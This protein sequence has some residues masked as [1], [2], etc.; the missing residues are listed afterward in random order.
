MAAQ[1]SRSIKLCGT[2][3]MDAPSRVLSAGALSVELENGQLRYIRIGGVEVI[4]AIAFLVR[5]ENWGTFTPTLENLKVDERAGGF[6]VTYRATCKDQKRTLVYDA[7]ITGASDGSLAFEVIADPVTDVETNRTGFIVLHPVKGIAG[8]PVK[9]LQVDG[10][11]V[12]SKFPETIDPDCP[13]RDIRALSHEVTPGVWATCTMEGDTF[14]MEDQRNWSDAS[15]KTY[16]RPLARP[17]PYTLPKGVKVEQAVRLSISGQAVAPAAGAAQKP[18]EIRLGGESGKMPAI[19]IGVP[20]EEAE[21]AL[22]SID[23]VKTLGPKWLACQVDLRQGHGRK[24]L[25]LYRQARRGD[26]RRNRARNRHQ[27]RHESR[28]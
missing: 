2:E 20:A 19:G 22:R 7:R 16:V 28:R 23:L 18:V 9:I 12:T 11:E 14:E 21:P 17:W 25:D 13:F 5:D 10:R 15:Y 8:A 1:A 27:R 26:G 24:E 3:E 4:R 6:T